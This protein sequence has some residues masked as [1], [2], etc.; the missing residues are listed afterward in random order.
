MTLSDSVIKSNGRSFR[1]TQVQSFEFVARDAVILFCTLSL[2]LWRRFP[3]LN[4][5]AGNVDHEFG[6]LGWIAGAFWPVHRSPARWPLGQLVGPP[7]SCFVPAF[8]AQVADFTI[9]MV[10]VLEWAG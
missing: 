2:F 4:L 8:N 5:A 3:I 6:E 7:C 9:F 1:H 10:R